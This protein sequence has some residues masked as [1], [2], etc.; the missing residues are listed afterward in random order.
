MAQSPAKGL[1]V[2]LALL[3][4]ND[5]L[6]LDQVAVTRQEIHYIVQ[7]PF[8]WMFG[9]GREAHAQ[10]QQS[11]LVG[12]NK[13]KTSG[14]T[15]S[16]GHVLGEGR[17]W[18]VGRGLGQGSGGG[19]GPIGGKGNKGAYRLRI[20]SWNIGTLTGKSIELAKILQKR[21]VNIDC[22][23]EIRWVGSKAR[24]ADG[25]KLWYSGGVKGKNEVGILVDREL[26]DGYG[27]VHS[28]FYCGVRNGG[29][30]SLLDFARAFELVIVNSIFSKNEENLITFRSM[31]AKTQIDY[32]LLR[33]CDKGLC[34]DC[35][36]IPSENLTTQHR[37]LVMNISI[38]I[39]RKKSFLRGQPRIRWG[40]LTKDTALELEGKLAT[41]RSWKSGGDASG[42]WTATMDCIREAARE[43]L[44]VSKGFSGRHRGDWWWNDVVHSKVEAK[45]ADYLKLVESTDGEQM[46]SNRERYK[47][48]R[49]EAKVAVTEAKTVVFGRLYE[50]LVGESGDKKLFQLAK[51]RERKTRDLEQVRCIK[52]EEGRVLMEEAQS[53]Q[54]WQS[55]FHRLLNEEGDKNIELGELWHSESHQDFRYC[56]RIEVEEVVGAMHKMSQGKATG[57]D[58]IPVEFWRMKRMPDE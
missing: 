49:R 36:V 45:K 48:A 50:E 25:Y 29:G 33:R 23:Q 41:M 6:K 53:K 37:L 18:V 1:F 42:K 11:R 58:E 54:R 35:K 14:S 55:Y 21:K 30:T 51:A 8:L 16:R 44:G 24:N 2:G 57:P 5:M 22:V 52:D 56:G 7:V 28:G 19:T 17:W 3:W 26:R 31:V 43:V 4:K 9:D 40:A 13:N 27:E 15:A 39:K 32:L 10:K 47:E 46:R 38:L 12:R 20:G 34:E